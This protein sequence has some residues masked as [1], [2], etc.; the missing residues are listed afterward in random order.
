MHLTCEGFATQPGQT[1]H[2]DHTGVQKS[3]LLSKVAPEH[4]SIGRGD[5]LS[6]SNHPH[7]SLRAS[8][9]GFA[10]GKQAGREFNTFYA[11]AAVKSV[12]PAWFT[13]LIGVA[14]RVQWGRRLGRR[15]NEDSQ[16]VTVKLCRLS[17][18]SCVGFF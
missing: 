18:L 5:A 2:P 16:S 4:D 13:S 11:P 12:L 9:R 15:E 1:C 17:E 7:A 10:K 6:S 14:V 8:W 3:V